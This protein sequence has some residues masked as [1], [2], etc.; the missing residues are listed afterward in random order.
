MLVA[1]GCAPVASPCSIGGMAGLSDGS[2]LNPYPSMHLMAG[3]EECRIQIDADT[4]DLGSSSELDRSALLRRDGFSPANTLVWDSKQAID[5]TTFPGVD[6]FSQSLSEDSGIQLWDL[7]AGTRVPFFAELDAYPDLEPEERVLLIRPL[8][9][10]GFDRHIA[11]VVTN[12][13][14][15]TAG[16]PLQAPHDFQIVR[17]SVRDSDLEP[18][19]V[20]H[21]NGLLGKLETLGVQRDSVVF[22]WDFRTGSKANIVA[23]LERVVE[24]M[25]ATLPLDRET[26]PEVEIS[27]S[28]DSDGGDAVSAGLWREI[29]G[30]VAL[31]HFL[32]DMDG[33]PTASATD[34]DHGWFSLDEEGLP[35][36][37]DSAPA[38]FTAIVPES[39]KDADPGTAP[40][41]VFGHG[42]FSSPQRYLSAASD[43]ESTIEL[44]NRLQAI[45]LG[46]EWRG[47][48]LRD[49]P[50]ALRAAMD[51]SRFPLV[52]DKLHQGVANQLAMA[53]IMRTSFVESEFFE[54]R[55]DGG[56]LVDPTRIYYFGISLGGIQGATL[57]ANSEVLDTGVLHVPGAMWTTMLERSVHWADFEDFVVQT[58]P[59]AKARQFVYAMLQLFWDPVDPITHSDQLADKNVLWQVSRGDEQVPNFTAEALIRSAGVP[60]AEPAIW[61]VPGL[62]RLAANSPP[63][64][65]ALFQWD[66]GI[67][68]PE[69]INR[70][71]PGETGAHTSIRHLDPLMTQVEGYF[72]AGVEG[73]VLDV[74]AGPCVFDLGDGD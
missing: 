26:V 38:Y 27:N 49:S 20:A 61:D 2:L 44:C 24:S 12:A 16:Q 63:G 62:G 68:A 37:R 56:S 57:L 54:A 52:T 28:L 35:V 42:I 70:P 17:D 64:H 25:R 32:W 5:A 9:S 53:R 18:P 15:T 11:A 73:Q 67:P 43:P 51:L 13:V 60:L 34:H 66:S 65:S 22:A 14:H 31:P 74:C 3:G 55:G 1:S 46:T 48:T 71:P 59:S 36:A 45:C 72:E 6:A 41:I 4:L 10:F 30:S 7:D 69:N 50:D 23:P 29:R 39:L 33:D 40:V 47:L 8:T 58:L 19:V 21:Y